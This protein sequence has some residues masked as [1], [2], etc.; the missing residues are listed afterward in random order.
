MGIV[1]HAYNAAHGLVPRGAVSLCTIA[2]YV[3]MALSGGSRP[4]MDA[5]NAASLGCFDL[6]RLISDAGQSEA[7]HSTPGSF[8]RS[9]TRFPALGE[10]VPG[11][12]VFAGGRR[13]PGELPRLGARCRSTV[14]F[15]VGTGS[16]VS[17]RVDSAAAIAGIDIR[18]FPFGGFLA[19]GAAL[20]GGT[21]YAL[22]RHFFERTVAALHWNEQ[23]QSR[24]DAMNAVGAGPAL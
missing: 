21:A 5:T 18:P 7:R 8:P 17:V 12:P 23:P 6:D 10:R 16:Q 2:D 22:L 20:C 14:L 4:R 19:V 9:P 11:M 13:Q 3:A 15:N 1:T 24:W